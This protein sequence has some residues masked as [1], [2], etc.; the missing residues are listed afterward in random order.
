VGAHVSVVP[1]HQNGRITS[2]QL[3]T[4]MA[5]GGNF[6]YELDLLKLSLDEK[7]L[8]KSHT[9]LYRDIE[10][11]VRYSFFLFHFFIKIK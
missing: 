5:F 7:V 10:S 3:R 11:I 8:I 9:N 4:F 2:L 6:G 1:N